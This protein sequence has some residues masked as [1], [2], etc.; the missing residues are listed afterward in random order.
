MILWAILNE[1]RYF[2][3][4]NFI[5]IHTHHYHNEL[6][7][8]HIRRILLSKLSSMKFVFYGLV[9]STCINNSLN[10]YSDL[11]MIIKFTT[12]KT[13]HLHICLLL[14]W[15]NLLCIGKKIGT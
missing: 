11:Q 1:F 6:T 14:S 8:M 5:E 10:S 13:V 7:L 2:M 9:L 3:R 15:Y 12:K 4:L